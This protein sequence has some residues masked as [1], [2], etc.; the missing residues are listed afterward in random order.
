MYSSSTVHDLQKALTPEYVRI[1]QVIHIAIVT[2]ALFF[3]MAV[4]FVSGVRGDGIPGDVEVVR[5]LS[6]VHLGFGLSVYGAATYL[7]E[8]KFRISAHVQSGP[9]LAETFLGALRTASIIRLAMFECVAFF[10]LVVCLVAAQAG[11]LKGNPEY[12][13]NTLSTV[14]L[15][16][17][18]ATAFPSAERIEALF[19]E[20]VLDV[21]L[22]PTPI[23]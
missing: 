23:H 18:V 13:L 3:L 16:G 20:K 6:I 21:G 12:W 14:I 1:L 17:L 4:L 15:V 22:R 19:R 5:L 10:G 7:Y 8:S 11:I 9:Q 2:G